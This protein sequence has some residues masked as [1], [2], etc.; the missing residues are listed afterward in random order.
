MKYKRGAKLRNGTLSKLTES[1]NSRID[2]RCSSE[3]YTKLENLA[4]RSQIF[5]TRPTSTVLSNT[6]TTASNGGGARQQTAAWRASDAAL[7]HGRCQ[8]RSRQRKGRGRA[9]PKG[10]AEGAEGS[11]RSFGGARKAQEEA[12]TPISHKKPALSRTALRR[13]LVPCTFRGAAMRR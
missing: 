10:N 9:V 8:S 1:P 7:G 6:H 5:L 12:G 4:G 3:Y 13:A 2:Y 11:F